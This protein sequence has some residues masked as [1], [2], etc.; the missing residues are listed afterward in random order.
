MTEN[1]R[2]LA[3][4]LT[5]IVA[6]VILGVMILVFR[7]VPSFI[8][9][10]YDVRVQ[11]S[12]AAGLGEGADAMLAGRRV[13]RVARLEFTDGDPR[14]GVTITV[15]IDRGMRI[16]GTA[17][18]YIRSKGFTGGNILEFRVDAAPPGAARTGPGGRELEWLPEDGA[19]VVQGRWSDNGV[20]PQ[21]LIAEARGALASLKRLSDSLNSFLAPPEAASAP[22]AEAALAAAPGTATATSTAPAPPNLQRSLAKMDAALTAIT[23]MLGDPENQANLTAALA[24]FK[25]AAAATA[26]AMNQVKQMAS[27]AQTTATQFTG[28]AQTTSRRVDDLAGR[29]LQTSDRM[30]E[31]LTTLNNSAHKLDTTDGTLGKLLNDPRLYNDLVD[32][33]TQ[34][35][36]TLAGMEELMQQWKDQGV[37]MKLK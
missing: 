9:M 35:K 23:Q 18:A 5:V 34:L 24:N 29:L 16:P 8:R 17:N 28:L 19:V 21:D 31:L 37:K 25:A 26:D 1:A 32:T 11:V 4:G 20:V 30:G 3:V 15:V 6:L 27:A 10:G 33:M 22:G 14:Q 12:D 2:N 36:S 7:E 13:G